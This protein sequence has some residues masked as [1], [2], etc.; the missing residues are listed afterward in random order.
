MPEAA[1]DENSDPL[2]WEDEVSGA[3]KTCY[4]PLVDEIAKPASM[5]DSA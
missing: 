2:G 4:G 5:Q 1:V 3:A